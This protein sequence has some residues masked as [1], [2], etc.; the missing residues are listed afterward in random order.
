VHAKSRDGVRPRKRN[1][2]VRKNPEKGLWV[3]FAGL[4]NQEAGITRMKRVPP[5]HPSRG[6][7]CEWGRTKGAAGTKI[8]KPRSARPFGGGR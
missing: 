2:S 3:Y 8:E 4:E 7:I 1:S 5:A 6:N